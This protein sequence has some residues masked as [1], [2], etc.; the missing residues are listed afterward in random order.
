MLK[1]HDILRRCGAE[2]LE[3]ANSASGWA[4]L[5]ASARTRPDDARAR[6]LA[7]THR[8]NLGNARRAELGEAV[9]EMALHGR[10]LCVGAER[11]S[12]STGSGNLGQRPS[13]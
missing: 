8:E 1:C 2:D 3:T 12:K 11:P 5:S 4:Q 7:S 10:H 13:W 9:R 6:T